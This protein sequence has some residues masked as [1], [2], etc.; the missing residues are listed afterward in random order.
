VNV[1]CESQAVGVSHNNPITTCFNG[2]P[3]HGISVCGNL[4]GAT[5]NVL[6]VAVCTIP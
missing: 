4:T 3:I 5:P 2:D 6:D 1:D